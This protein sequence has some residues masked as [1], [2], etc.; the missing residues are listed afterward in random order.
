MKKGP[1]FY[2]EDVLVEKH[3]NGEYNW[4]DYIAH[5]SEE[6]CEEYEAFCKTNGFNEDDDTAA[7]L[8]VE[9]KDSELEE[10]IAN[11]DA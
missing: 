11:G 9:H 5:H 8:F 1:V 3:Q 6:W 10:A 4:V 2:T 7:A